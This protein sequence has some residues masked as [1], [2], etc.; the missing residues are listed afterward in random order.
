STWSED[1]FHLGLPGQILAKNTANGKEVQSLTYGWIGH[2]R[3]VQRYDGIN[4]LADNFTYDAS[5]QLFDWQRLVE[6]TQSRSDDKYNYSGL[7]NF[8]LQGESGLAPTYGKLGPH[9]PDSDGAGNAYAYDDHGNQTAAPGRT[10][11]FNQLDLMTSVTT[12]AGKYRFAYDGEMHRVSRKDPSGDATFTFGSLFE[13]RARRGALHNVYKVPLGRAATLELDTVLVGVKARQRTTSYVL[14]DHLGS[15]DTLLS[16]GPDGVQPPADDAP[17]DPAPTKFRPFGARVAAS[18]ATVL[19]ASPPRGIREGFA[20]HDDDDELQ[21]VDMIG[22]VYDSIQGRFLTRDPVPADP[23]LPTSVN[24]Y[25][26]VRNDPLDFIDPTG[27]ASSDMGPPPDMGVPAIRNAPSKNQEPV[28]GTKPG[29]APPTNNSAA[30]D[31]SV[32]SPNQGSNPFNGAQSG[33]RPQAAPSPWSPGGGGR[34]RG[35]GAG[36][37]W[38]SWWDKVTD[39]FATPEGAQTFVNFT[40]GLMQSGEIGREIYEATSTGSHA[41]EPFENEEANHVPLRVPTKAPTRAPRGARP[42]GP[43]F[44]AGTQIVMADGSTRGIE[45]IQPGDRVMTADPDGEVGAATSDG[46]VTEEFVSRTYRVVHVEIDDGDGKPE[47]ELQATGKHPFWVQGTGWKDAVELV[48]GDVLLDAQGRF[49]TVAHRWEESRDVQTF[50]LSVQGSHTYFVEAGGL[51]VLVH[52]Q[53]EDPYARPS[54]FRQGVRDA[55]WAAHVEAD[56]SVRDFTTGEIILPPGPWDMGHLPGYEFSKLQAFAKKYGI[57][58]EQFRDM[59]N[60]PIYYRPEHP[61]INRMHVGEDTH[62]INL[63]EHDLQDSLRCD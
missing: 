39:F 2:S 51:T 63:Y 15:A 36:G 33:G 4:G 12:A 1:S 10:V 43:C 49:V 34:F 18:D 52:N 61:Q 27:Y 45:T 59:Y 9:Q 26:Y 5:H 47:G 14:L 24:P 58:A 50:N 6:A 20:G 46:T 40:D 42:Q 35:H 21:L 29:S 60:N 48:P 53:D 37:S 28:S 3:L 32:H 19:V 41:P 31:S 57:G 13:Q 22:R 7:G 11:A 8:T 54:G 38:G 30:A 62:G 44:L 17:V 55:V 25:A 56:G 23:T 16:G